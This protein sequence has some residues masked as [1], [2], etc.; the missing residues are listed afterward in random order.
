MPATRTCPRCKTENDVARS[1]CQECGGVMLGVGVSMA[2]TGYAPL[3]TAA[4]P[5]D[6]IPAAIRERL[7]KAKNL[8]PEK[9]AMIAA[10]LE[11][12]LAQPAKPSA[13]GQDA[14]PQAKGRGVGCV[15]A[16]AIAVLGMVAS[17]LLFLD[18]AK[19]IEEKLKEFGTA[20][21]A[22]A[23]FE[24]QMAP[25]S[26]P[27]P[28]TDVAADLEEDQ[29]HASP[30]DQPLL[31]EPPP[32]RPEG[33][34]VTRAHLR[35]LRLCFHG[36]GYPTERPM[37]FG[38]QV[39]ADIDAAAINVFAMTDVQVPSAVG[40]CLKKHVPAQRW[41]SGLYFVDWPND[42]AWP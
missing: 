9:Q 13:A 38:I 3:P 12:R 29:V 15:F 25:P 26:L 42:N 19:S 35:P 23:R 11:R 7:A 22:S 32:P 17:T 33:Q 5:D 40:L 30:S 37:Q 16:I 14:G 39:G 21:S 31:A 20:K 8:S 28:A 36:L 4:A 24:V 18:G 2:T 27:A 41:S 10:M 6:D 1:N 34:T